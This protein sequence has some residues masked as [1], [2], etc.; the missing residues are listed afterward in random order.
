VKNLNMSGLHNGMISPMLRATLI[1]LSFFAAASAWACQVPVFRY[2]LERWQPGLYRVSLPEGL[3][4]DP[5]AN[6]EVKQAAAGSQIELYFPSTLR[7]ATEKPLWSAPMSEAN[8][9]LMVDSPIRQE[10]RKRLLAGESAVWLLIESGDPAKD[11][12]AGKALDD[13]L[14]AAQKKLKL[15]DGVLT[16]EEAK[17]PKKRHENADVLLSDLP[18]RI[19][20]ST[21]RL[22]RQNADEAALIAMLMHIEPDLGDF[23][24][25]PMVFPIFGRGRALE[26]IL[27]KGIHAANL[28]EAC[29]Y[30]CGACSCEIKEQN[31]GIDLLMVAD[32]GAVGTEAE[33]PVT[34]MITPKLAPSRWTSAYWI[35]GIA[36]LLGAAAWL[37]RGF[38]RG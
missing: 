34:V 25:E 33:L 20:F 37:M 24:D 10:L 4:A 1:L 6:L 17:D 38:L 30:L 12:A 2:A 21:L 13:G 32:W 26:P 22:S 35:S 8:V 14:Q 7:Q 3:K 27:G 36:A 28:L 15:P 11:D 19:A 18:L 29:T 23:V 5:H 16:Q 9:R 31:P